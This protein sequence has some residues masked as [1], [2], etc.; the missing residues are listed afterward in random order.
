MNLGINGGGIFSFDSIGSG[1]V[2][3]YNVSGGGINSI[4]SIILGGSGYQVGDLTNVNAGNG[5]AILR[6]SSVSSGAVTGMQVVYGG[7]GYISAGGGSAV[8]ALGSLPY[9]FT[10]TGVLTSNA[11]I[12][13]TTG[14]YL[15]QSNQWCVNNNT[16]GPY[17]VT[18][19]LGNGSGVA[20]GTGVVIPQGTN[21]NTS[22]QIQTDGENDIW[23]LSVPVGPTTG[24]GSLVY[25]SNAT[26][27]NVTIVGGNVTANTVTANNHIATANIAVSSTAGAFSY[28]NL[29]YSDVGLVA[30]F[31]NSANSSVQF[32]IQNTD[33]A[34]NAS[35]DL[36]VVNDTGVAYGD[37]GITASDYSGTGA[38]YKAN[39]V[40]VYS[41][42][43]DLYIGTVSNNAT[44]FVA[45]NA[46]TDAMV[47]NANNTV[48]INAYAGTTNTNASFTSATMMLTPVGY[49]IFNINGTNYKIPYYN[50]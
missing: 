27:S 19:K 2:V 37:F 16:T 12:V 18:F 5:D 33:T 21:S 6:V 1:C 3:A 13:T 25:S 35:T 45:N 23:L 39:V 38:F 24:T 9:T 22:C 4:L 47:L 46:T 7:T 11:T 15:T 40:Y 17:S 20:I 32:V 29:S 43:T 41:G 44:H 26:L 30:S 14:T 36:V 10:L 50:T 42:S 8:M 31:A 48:T 34:S 49:L 28:G